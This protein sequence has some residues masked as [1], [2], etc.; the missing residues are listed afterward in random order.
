MNTHPLPV[1]GSSAPAVAEDPRIQDP[2]AKEKPVSPYAPFVNTV[3][4][5]AGWVFAWG[6]AALTFVAY[7]HTRTLPFSTVFLDAFGNLS[8]LILITISSFLFLVVTTVHRVLKGKLLL[9]I[10]LMIAW[11]AAVFF[12]QQNM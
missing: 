2:W 6:L 4:L 9:G 7:G 11:V 3:R 1:S 5:Y 12:V 8:A 10:V